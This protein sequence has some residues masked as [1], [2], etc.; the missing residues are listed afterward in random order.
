[1][2]RDVSTIPARR[3]NTVGLI[4]FTEWFNT[5]GADNN[6]SVP[7]PAGLY[8][9][10]E[11][12]EA[13]D[14]VGRLPKKVSSKIEMAAAINAA[15]GNK[16]EGLFYDEGFWTAMALLYGDV[17]MPEYKGRRRLSSISNYV[18]PSYEELRDNGKGYRHRVWGPCY[19][20]ARFGKLSRAFLTGDM[21]GLADPLDA[22]IFYNQAYLSVVQAIDALYIDVNGEFIGDGN[23]LD[24][25]QKQDN[26]R[27]G[28]VRDFIEHCLQ[29]GYTHSLSR[30]SP[31]KLITSANRMEFGPQIDNF[32]ARK[33][34]GSLPWAA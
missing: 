33:A 16:R 30:V 28:R 10:P 22:L 1:M 15:L 31:E 19:I 8:S 21:S 4:R 18:M 9:D 13:V 20:H 24:E 17:I 12:S 32:E 34:D 14:G 27:P 6:T 25:R 2:L 29:V 7:L 23:K 3:L 11:T 26:I 5:K